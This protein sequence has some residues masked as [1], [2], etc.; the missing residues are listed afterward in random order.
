ATLNALVSET[1][2]L[3]DAAQAG[4]L[5]V[6][7][8][9]HAFAGG[10]RDL[11]TGINSTLDALLQP[12]AAASDVLERLAARDLTARV[13]ADYQGDHGKITSALNEASSSL[14]DALG[15]VRAASHEIA[16]AGS[17]IST[18]SQHLATGA[19]EQAARVEE[20]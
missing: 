6:R 11:V 17:Q 12:V 16:S 15:A 10:Y 1:R 3:I 8:D 2:Q 5:E 13:E 4:R 7:G 14:N 20:I 19:S 9:A 18:T